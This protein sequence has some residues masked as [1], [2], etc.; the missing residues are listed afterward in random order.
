MPM[1]RVR[2][3]PAEAPITTVHRTTRIEAR[4]RR[5]IDGEQPAVSTAIVTRRDS[6]HLATVAFLRAVL[7]AHA[8]PTGLVA[9]GAAVTTAG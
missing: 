5:T 1:F 9:S 6:T 2:H 3:P 4:Q 7:Q 8:R